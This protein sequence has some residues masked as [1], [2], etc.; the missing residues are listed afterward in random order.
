MIPIDQL[1]QG[2][3]SLGFDVTNEQSETLITYLNELLLI[4]QS[5]NLTSITE[6]SEAIDLHLL[7]SLT[8]K[9]WLDSL[10]DNSL[11]LDIG[12]GAGLPGIPIAIMYPNV[13]VILLDARNKKM[14]ACQTLIDH[15]SLDNI[16]TVHS[17]IEDWQP[18]SKTDVDLILARAV[19]KC[20]TIINWV[21]HIPHKH[22]LL[23]KGL[24]P[25]DELKNIKQAPKIT[26]VYIP[27]RSEKRHILDFSKNH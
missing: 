7:D 11:I 20:E 23:M 4:N 14:K 10:G 9:P 22:L 24:R 2:L 6:L 5:L 16:S 21:R 26:Q 27:N 15:L 3:T 25:D 17:R 18:P 13:E 19:A 12:S 8:L 1:S